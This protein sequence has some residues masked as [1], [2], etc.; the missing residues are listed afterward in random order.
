MWETSAW[1]GEMELLLPGMLLWELCEAPRM[2]QYTHPKNGR[3]TNALT[4]SLRFSK[5]CDAL[6]DASHV[7]RVRQEAKDADKK[8]RLA[9]P[10]EPPQSKCCED[11]QSDP[12]SPSV[13]NVTAWL[14]GVASSIRGEDPGTLPTPTQPAEPPSPQNLPGSII[15]GEKSFPKLPRRSNPIEQRQLPAASQGCVQTRTLPRRNTPPPL[16]N[17]LKKINRRRMSM[18]I[19]P[20]ANRLQPCGRGQLQAQNA[21]P[22]GSSQVHSP[23]LPFLTLSPFDSVAR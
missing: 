15:L 19:G 21:S 20:P 17:R 3:T 5:A 22:Y 14:A 4:I 8:L 23:L 16:A 2:T 9:L 1:A 11:L 13:P 10:E 7:R 12:G 18:P 6:S